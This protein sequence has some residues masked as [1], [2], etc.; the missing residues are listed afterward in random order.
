MKTSLSI[1]LALLIAGAHLNQATTLSSLF[2]DNT[3][4]TM[5]ND[6]WA[7][8]HRSVLGWQDPY[9]N[10]IDNLASWISAISL[11]YLSLGSL[12]MNFLSEGF[13]LA[14]LEDLESQFL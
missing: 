13:S 10:C 7:S 8:F 2:Q 4:Y 14:I 11:I 5:T 3:S 12:G 6:F 9:S 1:V